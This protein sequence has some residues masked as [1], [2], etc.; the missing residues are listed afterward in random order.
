MISQGLPGHLAVYHLHVTCSCRHTC[1]YLGTTTLYYGTQSIVNRY[2]PLSR[3]SKDFFWKVSAV[4]TNKPLLQCNP[5]N[6]KEVLCDSIPSLSIH[7][8]HRRNTGAATGS[9]LVTLPSSFALVD[10]PRQRRNTDSLGRRHSRPLSLES[11]DE[12]LQRFNVGV[13]VVA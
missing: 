3:D 10:G 12:G 5:P 1:L 11:L 7:E 6:T 2:R 13:G 4:S 8:D 9:H